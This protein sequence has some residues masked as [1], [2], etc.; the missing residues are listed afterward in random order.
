LNYLTAT[1]QGVTGAQGTFQ[2]KA[3]ETIE[4]SIGG[5]KLGQVIAAENITPSDLTASG[6]SSDDPKLRN[7]LRL[8][9]SLDDDCLADNGIT[10]NEAVRTQADTLNLD[11]PDT[12]LGFEYDI[13]LLALLAVNSC[14]SNWVSVFQAELHYRLSMQANYADDLAKIAL[15]VL[16]GETE[17]AAAIDDAGNVITLLPGNVAYGETQRIV[18]TGESGNQVGISVDNN[19]MPS[20]VYLGNGVIIYLTNFTQDSVDIIISEPNVA[21]GA[22]FR[23]ELTGMMRAYY[24]Y[25]STLQ[26]VQ[27]IATARPVND[28]NFYAR[29]LD[30]FV[31]PVN[32]EDLTQQLT[33]DIKRASSMIKYIKAVVDEAKKIDAV[34]QGG[35]SGYAYVGEYIND[36]SGKFKDGLKDGLNDALWNATMN[37][38]EM[39]KDD[40]RV[41]GLTLDVL[42]CSAA[43]SLPNCKDAF[44]GVTGSIYELGGILYDIHQD[45][46]RIIAIENELALFDFIGKPPAVTLDYDIDGNRYGAGTPVTFSGSAYD[47][48]EGY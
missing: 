22:S 2:Y 17:P 45:R 42:Q 11:L 38:L 36:A 5:L 27:A 34:L 29:L 12:Q 13:D 16:D 41:L 37:Q 32:A 14:A 4:F 21:N 6:L 31:S 15:I 26:A 33:D 35:T 8:L 7:M 20:H 44:F 18:M 9:Q 28:N 19:G 1:Q 43:V 10:L 40:E 24:R 25:F 39:D 3:G 47:P 48:D 30:F 46:D 23:V